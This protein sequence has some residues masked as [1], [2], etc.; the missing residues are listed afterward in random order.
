MQKMSNWWKN[1][2]ISLCENCELVASKSVDKHNLGQEKTF[3]LWNIRLSS[4]IKKSFSGIVAAIG[5]KI[6]QINKLFIS[7]VSTIST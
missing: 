6:E 2:W 7:E 4:G 3:R 5:G 1:L